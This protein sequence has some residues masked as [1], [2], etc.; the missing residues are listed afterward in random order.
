MADHVRHPG[1][2][3]RHRP[4]FIQNHR[5]H[6]VSDLQ[7]FRRFDQDPAGRSP[8]GAHHNGRGRRKAQSAGAGNDQYGNAD[9]EGEFESVS[10][11]EPDHRRQQ[12][13]GDD[14]RDEYAA[15]L[16][17][18][19]GDRRFGRSG[20]VHQLNDFG[21]S[22]IFPYRRS[23]HLEVSRPVD[24]AA[25]HFVPFLFFSG[26]ALPGDGGFV[27]GSAAFHD[28]SVH[29][30]RIAVPHRQQIPCLHVVYGDLR[31]LPVF[32]QDRGLGRQ[33]HQFRDRIGCPGLRPGFHKF[34]QRNQSQDHSG[35]F[36]V[37]I[38]GKMVHQLRIPVAEPPGDLID[39]VNPVHERGP[40]SQR[41]EGIHIGRAMPEVFKSVP[42]IV[43]SRRQHRQEE[44]KLGEREDH[45]V[46]SSQQN[47]RQRPARHMPHGNI[48][49]RHG[50]NQGYDQPLFHAL[51]LRCRR[52]RTPG[53]PCGRI[54]PRFPAGCVHGC[55]VS[56][57]HH[58][59]DDL[60][61]IRSVLVIRDGHAVF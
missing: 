51:H 16:I 53:L 44:Q 3:F 46:L 43:P 37:Q 9:G 32:D 14:C 48:E 23:L 10:H 18:Q 20:F 50:E 30:H 42:E 29:G 34:P 45:R 35:G 47:G 6:G 49:K 1:G 41:D 11:R 27:D 2:S 24:G 4:G 38:H 21:Q 22:R 56:D 36:E 25:G 28:F 7:R 5:I 31:F 40:G 19:F 8:A 61:R 26:D 33:I 58:L 15:D 54:F 60:L 17:R 13:D 55:A 57:V 12:G 52:I 39:G 59:I